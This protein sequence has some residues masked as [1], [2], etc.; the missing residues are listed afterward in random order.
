MHAF[1]VLLGSIMARCAFEAEQLRLNGKIW[2]KHFT[3]NASSLPGIRMDAQC[4]SC[5]I[6]AVCY[7]NYVQ[8]V[9]YAVHTVPILARENGESARVGILTLRRGREKESV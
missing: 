3:R 4:C 9:P 5:I 6:V 7:K 1:R 2:S 8:S